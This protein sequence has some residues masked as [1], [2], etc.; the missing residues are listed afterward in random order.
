MLFHRSSELLILERNA[1]LKEACPCPPGFECN[2]A[3]NQCCPV[4]AIP[5]IPGN[6]TVAPV[7]P[8]VTVRPATVDP[9][10]ACDDKVHPKTGKSDCPTLVA[11]CDVSQYMSLMTEQCPKTC[12]RCPTPRPPILRCIDL[13][14]PKTNVS[15]CPARKNLCENKVYEDV[16][17]V[18]CPR[19]CKLCTPPTARPR[20]MMP[21]SFRESRNDIM[22][23]LLR[24]FTNSKKE[25]TPTFIDKAETSIPDNNGDDI[26]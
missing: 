9:A 5:L 1:Q 7:L 20:L 21:L 14:N 22:D 2:A 6:L 12:R 11:L 23:K 13:L 16:M 10:T 15:D 19:T 3:I 8:V 25:E 18:Q 24:T 26:H 17:R 4:P